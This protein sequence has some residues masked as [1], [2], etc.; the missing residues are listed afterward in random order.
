MLLQLSHYPCTR[1]AYQWEQHSGFFSRFSWII[2]L[3]CS[4]LIQLQNDWNGSYCTTLFW[5][6]SLLKLDWR[7]SLL[8]NWQ[9]CAAH[10]TVKKYASTPFA[11]FF[12]YSK[13]PWIFICRLKRVQTTIGFI[14]LSYQFEYLKCYWTS[15]CLW[16]S[17]VSSSSSRHRK[18][19]GS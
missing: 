4:L 7:A 13:F 2:K 9:R 1:Y 10:I 5:K 15:I 17:C 3:D 18:K 14:F 16:H 11:W 12:Q 19:R 8:D 6:C